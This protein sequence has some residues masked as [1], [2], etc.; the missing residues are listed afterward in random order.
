MKQV[1]FTLDELKMIEA[2]LRMA[3]CT[4]EDFLDGWSD[5]KTNKK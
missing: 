1:I 3:N 2:A 4:Y 5:P